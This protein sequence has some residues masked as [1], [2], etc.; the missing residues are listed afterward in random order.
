MALSTTPEYFLGSASSFEPV[1]AGMKSQAIC[2]A[3][4]V[5][6]HGV[7]GFIATVVWP[8]DTTAGEVEI[9]GADLNQETGF[10][11]LGTIAFPARQYWS[12]SGLVVNFM[13][14][15]VVT[16]PVGAM[17]PVAEYPLRQS[18]Y[19]SSPGMLMIWTHNYM[20]LAAGDEITFDGFAL[21]PVLNGMVFTVSENPSVRPVPEGFADWGYGG[22]LD[23]ID[24]S[25]EGA[26]VAG[27]DL[28]GSLIKFGPPGLAARLVIR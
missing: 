8:P 20:N 9:Q 17:V 28:A 18:M 10:A 27:S 23:R 21:N 4:A 7:R 24:V 1:T 5:E 11:T 25:V 26:N 15:K 3:P 19:L 14:V 2:L 6:V 13:R 16:A 22:A 12:P